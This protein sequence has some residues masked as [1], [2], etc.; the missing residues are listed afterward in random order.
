VAIAVASRAANVSVLGVG[1]LTSIRS[2]AGLSLR[3][4]LAQ[5]GYGNVRK[6]LNVEEL[7][8]LIA[9]Q[10][11]LI[12]EWDLY[13]ADKRTTGGWYLNAARREIGQIECAESVEQF[14]TPE[15]AVAEYVLRELDFWFNLGLP[16]NKSLERTR[17][18]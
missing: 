10:P 14:A 17:E 7:K 6:D 2:E 11:N 9:Q 5:V 18:R 15:E 4:A 13:S 1:H 3:D 8:G 16:P 12:E